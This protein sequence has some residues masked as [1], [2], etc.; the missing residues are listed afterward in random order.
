VAAAGGASGNAV[1]VTAGPA[2]VCTASGTT[3]TFVGVGTCSVAANQAGS[4]AYDAA[5]Q[6]TQSIK[7]DYRFAGFLQPVD[8]GDVL[9]TAKAGQV[10]PLRW[11]LTDAD[12]LPVTTLTVATI[13]VK[14]LSCALGSTTDQVEEYAA[15][16]SGL[17]NLGDGNYQLNWRSPTSY[18]RSCK[19]L[20]LALGDGSVTYTARFQFTK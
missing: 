3:V 8:G 13:T 11:R 10:I 19:T 20:T 4:S 16:G 17:Q 12:G 2:G 5:A 7:V 18:A 6:V 14:D 9:N 1:A 15:G